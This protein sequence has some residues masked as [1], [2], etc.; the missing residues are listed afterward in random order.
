MATIDINSGDDITINLDFDID[1]TGMTAYFMAKYWRSDTDANAAINKN[2]SS[3]TDASAGTI[4][5]SLTD[6]EADA[7]QE[8]CLY[9]QTW[10]VDGS[11]NE[12]SADSGILNVTE[13]LR[14]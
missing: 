13:N 4:S 7:I 2:S 6:V 14:D 5:I 1:C 9:W 10:L 8:T 12:S 3:W 11:S